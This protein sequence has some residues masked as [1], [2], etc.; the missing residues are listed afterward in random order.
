MESSGGVPNLPGGLF[1][2]ATDQAFR[3]DLQK[4]E[5]FF[6]DQKLNYRIFTATIPIR[7]SKWG[8]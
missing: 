3:S 6:N 1:V 7:N 2:E 4:I 8:L 5:Q